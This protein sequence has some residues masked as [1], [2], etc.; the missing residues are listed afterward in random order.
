M[1]ENFGNKTASDLFHDG[2]SKSLPRKYWQRTIFLLDVMDA[3]EDIA[4]LKSK[5]QPP[6][7]R[8]HKLKGDMAGF[9]AVDIHKSD[10]W[11]ITFK[12]AEGKFLDVKVLDYH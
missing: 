6:S 4:D 7:L 1:I 9:W 10:G 3:V 8:L 2:K 11:R 5:G 12:F